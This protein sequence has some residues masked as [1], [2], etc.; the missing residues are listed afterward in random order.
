MWYIYHVRSTMTTIATTFLNFPFA[1]QIKD[2]FN[3]YSNE[4][5]FT[6]EG[7]FRR[8]TPPACPCCGKQ[9]SHNGYNKY[10]ILNISIIKLGRYHCRWCSKSSQ[11]ENIFIYRIKYEISKIFTDLYHV[12]RN[13]DVSYEGISEVMDYL[14]PQSRDTICRDFSDSVASVQ[15]P[16]ASRIQIIHYD[17]QHPKAGRSQKYRLTLLNG[18]SHEVIA[19]ELSDNKSKE[20]IKSFFKNN[21]K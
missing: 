17:E 9:M 14:V 15:L 12:L 11:E 7:V 5:E 13:H 10:H 18:V 21:L 1:N 4:Y 3:E 6:A 8:I 2:A 19:E 16:E 20:V